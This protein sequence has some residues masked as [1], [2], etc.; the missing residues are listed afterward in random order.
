MKKIYS[1]HELQQKPKNF[2]SFFV[3][4]YLH[5]NFRR[6]QG[7]KDSFLDMKKESA[8]REVAALLTFCLFLANYNVRFDCW[9]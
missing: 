5:K 7:E 9:N 3:G 8:R 4:L 1:W 6:N 2:K